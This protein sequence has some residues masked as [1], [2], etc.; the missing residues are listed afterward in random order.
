MEVRIYGIKGRKGRYEEIILTKEE[1]VI[2]Y[3]NCLDRILNNTRWYLDNLEYLSE[4]RVN[5]EDYNSKGY[6][7]AYYKRTG[8]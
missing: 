2:W 4:F 3:E 6:R 5:W 7:K 8:K 1:Q